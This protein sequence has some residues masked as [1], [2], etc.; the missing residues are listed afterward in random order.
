MGSVV[1]SVLGDTSDLDYK[2][3]VLTGKVFNTTKAI[4]TAHVKLSTY[5]HEA[6]H[7][8]QLLA[9]IVSRQ[10]EGTAAGAQIQSFLEGVQIT[11]TELHIAQMTLKGIGYM[12]EGNIYQGTMMLFIAGLMQTQIIQQYALKAQMDEIKRMADVQ[13]T[14]YDS[15]Q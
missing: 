15:Y 5:F 2:I 8:A 13:K 7:A 12:S 3:D 4:D 10:L 9:S 6:L 1:V 14:M 11:A